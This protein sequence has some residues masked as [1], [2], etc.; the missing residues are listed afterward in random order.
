[1]AASSMTAM[2]RSRVASWSPRTT[3]RS[4]PSGPPSEAQRLRPDHVRDAADLVD[5]RIGQRL[6]DLD[7]G[8]GVLAR[9]GATEMEGRDVDAVLAEGAAEIAD[10]AGLVLVA[11]EQHGGGRLGPPGGAPAL[12]QARRFAAGR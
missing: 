1:M 7:E 4:T 12:D 6:V 5:H 10:E 9:R 8:D 2:A 3:L 11:D